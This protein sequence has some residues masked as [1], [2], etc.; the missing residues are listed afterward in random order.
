MVALAFT[1]LG[2]QAPA[3]HA[4]ANTAS[5]TAYR[6][7]G[8][9][10]DIYDTALLASPVST[11]GSLRAKGVRT[12]FLETSNYGSAGDIA[13]P[14]R[15]R[16]FIEA[17]HDSGL[18]VVAWYLPGFD[19]LDRDLR[20]SKAAIDL[21]TG[22]GDA[23]DSFALDIEATRVA[24]AATRSARVVTLSTQIR[25]YVGAS[26]PLGAI[27]PSPQGMQLRPAF[28]PG[29]PWSDLAG[30]YDAFVPMGYYTYHVEGARAVHAETT[31]NVQ[32]IRSATGDSTIPIHVAGGLAA[33]SDDSETR[34]FV[35][36]ARECGVLGVS[37]YDAATSSP[38]DWAEIAMMPVN[39]RQVPPLPRPIPSA[40][41]LGNV[42]GSDRTHPKEV[43]FRSGP[44]RGGR[45]LSLRVYD[46][47]AGELE[48]WVN[49]QRIGAFRPNTAGTWSSWRVVRIPDAALYADRANYVHVIARGR[50]PGWRTWGLRDVTWA[51]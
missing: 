45:R 32:L 42:P 28:W 48:L 49:W 29:F 40:T 25:T 34:A 18:L 20:R 1:V 38:G 27:T 44:I 50:Y 3:A 17:A 41:V 26:Y 22:R 47:Q 31:A 46:V 35:R 15:T 43:F 7:P 10:I 8:A 11:A 12:V 16:R 5:L 14:S 36:A 6:G 21:R 13:Y 37:L 4:L 9:W 39:P 33:E 2:V 23:F 51:P 24:N 30:I 19:D